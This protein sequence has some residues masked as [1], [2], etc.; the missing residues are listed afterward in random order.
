MVCNPR[1]AYSVATKGNGD[2]GYESLSSL[3]SAIWIMAFAALNTTALA[4]PKAKAEVDGVD[5]VSMPRSRPRAGIGA[6][7]PRRITE[8]NH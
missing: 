3:G 7:R 5:G 1:D 4:E 2:D 6:P 8:A